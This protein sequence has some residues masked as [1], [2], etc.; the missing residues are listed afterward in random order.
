MR[1]NAGHA[2]ARAL[3]A[4]GVTHVFGMPG[5]HVLPIY[6]GIGLTAGMSTILTRHEHHAA[7]MAAGFAQLTGRPGVVLVTAGP[8]VTN[9]LTAVAEAFVGCIPMV[10]LGGRGS[11]LTSHKGASQEVPTDR[12]FAPVTKWS[13]RVD[14]AE[15]LPEIIREAFRVARSGRPG[16]VL[17]DIPRDVLVE[18][19]E[20]AGYLPSP[21]P[22]R[23]LADLGIIQRAASALHGAR[24]PVIIAGGGAIASEA[25][26]DITALAESL[27]APVLTSL[28]G[29]GIISEHHPLAVG[30]LGA[31]RN[32]VSRRVLAEADAVLAL[33]T[34]FEE[35][36]TNWQP[37]AVPPRSAVYIQ[38]DL[39]PGELGRS[40]P[41]DIPVVGDIRAVVREL[42]HAF[43]EL[44]TPAART[45]VPDLRAAV[46]RLDSW[47]EELAASDEVPINPV[48]VIRSAREVF[49][50]DTILAVDVGALAQHIAGA[51]PFFRVGQH[52][53]TIV[54]SSFYGMG[55]V[56]AAAPVAKLVHPDRPAL[57]FV[58]DG[59]FQMVMNVL[60]M[61]AQY[62]LGVTWVV[63]ND[64][65][66]GSIWDLQHHSYG[67][68][69][70]DTTFEY[71]PDLAA[72]ARGSGAHGETVT[73]PADVEGALRRALA[74]NLEGRP[75]VVD[76][77][78]ARLRLP[79]TR[80]HYFTTY[81]QDADALGPDLD[82][83]T[84]QVAAAPVDVAPVE[85]VDR[86]SQY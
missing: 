48:R 47:V 15:L 21:E 24:H 73:N 63:L 44:G 80:Q 82:A 36:E 39:E 65:A 4:E 49:P 62:G 3:R 12:I 64:H 51:F 28:S 79:Q 71:Q 17:V 72:I 40:V 26:A 75:A 14:R 37:G 7:A 61:A 27:K 5:G 1:I 22:Q 66:L 68:R 81:P 67:D 69:I 53:S 9:T 18:E 78:V 84:G 29:R 35:M 11:R 70:V 23:P 59:S 16:P 2:V 38:V 42:G 20:F 56:A 57:C 76:V 6:D 60:P 58:G 41:V 31:H 33:G 46:A 32:H 19:I 86:A 30:G 55:F 25:G 8:G 77:T 34:R 50:R 54:P 43:T 45:S 85:T 52:R 13:I 74:A 10:I 83:P